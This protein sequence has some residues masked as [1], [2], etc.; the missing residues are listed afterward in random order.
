MK[1]NMKKAILFFLLMIICV[2]V[3]IIGATIYTRQDVPSD[4]E[5][6]EAIRN[7]FQILIGYDNDEDSPVYSALYSGIQIKINTVSQ[8]DEDNIYIANC[9]LSN[10]DV[11]ETFSRISTQEGEMSTKEYYRLFS[12]EFSSSRI[13][14]TDCLLAI[15]RAEDAS[16]SAM[17][18]EEAFNAATGGWLS[19]LERLHEMEGFE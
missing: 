13:L 6:I 12:E 4:E 17:F 19:Q 15:R 5:V 2:V 8:T 14:S 16:Y 18:T 7:E 3:V 9:K 11:Q 10:Y 1:R